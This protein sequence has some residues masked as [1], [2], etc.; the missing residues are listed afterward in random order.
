LVASTQN[1]L[2]AAKFISSPLEALGLVIDAVTRINL[3]LHKK[4]SIQFHSEPG[5]AKDP[6]LANL[7]RKSHLSFSIDGLNLTRNELQRIA[8]SYQCDTQ[9]PAF[10]LKNGLMRLGKEAIIGQLFEDGTYHV[11]LITGLGLSHSVVNLSNLPAEL[12]K[13]QN[14]PLRAFLD[15]NGVNLKE[16]LPFQLRMYVGSLVKTQ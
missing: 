2:Y 3:P 10:D 5:S 15:Q 8:V 11:Y 9:D 16:T 1:I 7:L 13:E 6:S 14:R 4:C 12:K